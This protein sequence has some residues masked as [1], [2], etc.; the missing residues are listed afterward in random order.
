M[1]GRQSKYLKKQNEV[2]NSEPHFYI[3][4]T[5]KLTK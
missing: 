4:N 1:A 5:G 2:F 3:F